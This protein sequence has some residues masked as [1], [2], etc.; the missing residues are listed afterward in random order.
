MTAFDI[1]GAYTHQSRR[2]DWWIC[3]IMGILELVVIHSEA[4]AFNVRG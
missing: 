4:A 1:P 3:L 2:L